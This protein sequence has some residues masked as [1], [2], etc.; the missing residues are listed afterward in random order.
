MGIWQLVEALDVGILRTELASAGQGFGKR[1]IGALIMP[2]GAAA[3][4]IQLQ[5][6]ALAAVAINTQGKAAISTCRYAI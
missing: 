5:F 2:L 6:T 3:C 4:E 1:T